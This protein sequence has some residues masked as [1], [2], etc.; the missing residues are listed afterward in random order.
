MVPAPLRVGFN[1]AEIRMLLVRTPSDV[2][3]SG[4]NVARSTA[5]QSAPASRIQRRHP[6]RSAAAVDGGKAGGG[7]VKVVDAPVVDVMGSAP[8]SLSSRR[9][10]R[11]QHAVPRR[12]DVANNCHD[13]TTD[14]HRRSRYPHAVS[15]TLEDE[16]FTNFNNALLVPVGCSSRH[17]QTARPPWTLR[18]NPSE[19]SART[20]PCP[21]ASRRRRR[22]TAPDQRPLAFTGT[23]VW[24]VRADGKLLRNWVERSAWEVYQSLTKDAAR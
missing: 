7:F 5:Q 2:G 3:L 10:R 14:D 17:L 4:L 11:G 1:A 8:W 24:A 21:T 9:R 18:S 23:A 20:R 12:R 16:T 19:R 22:S 13:R 15:F 6:L